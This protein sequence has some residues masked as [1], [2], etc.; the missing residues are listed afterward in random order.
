MENQLSPLNQAQLSALASLSSNLERD[1][2]L[3]LNGYFQGLFVKHNQQVAVLLM[4][5]AEK[6]LKI[7]YGTHTGRSERIAS[8]LADAVS[9]RGVDVQIVALDNYNVRQLASETNIVCIVSTHG[10]GEPPA[11]AEDFHAFIT[12]KRAPLLP[13]LKYAVVAL[14]DKSYRLFCKTGLDIDQAFSNAGAQAILPVL[15]LD[16]DYEEEASQWVSRFA[17]VFV[18]GRPGTEIVVKANPVTEKAVAYSAKNPFHATVLDKVKITGRDSDKEV[19]H[20]EL[21]LEGS[22]ITYEP[23]D[24]VGILANNPPELVESIL[25]ELNLSGT[26]KVLIRNTEYALREALTDRLEITVLNR[27]FVQNYQK[28][29]RSEKL[30]QI[31]QD[32]KL[33]ED[34]LFGRDVLDLVQ[35]FPHQPDAQTLA[36]LLRVIPARLYSISSSQ[37]VVG[38]EVHITVAAVRFTRKGRSRAGACSSYLAD[39]IQIN[40]TVPVYIEK[41]PSFK[42]PENKETPIILIGAGTGIAPY[43]AFLQQRE[44]EN[45]KGKTWLFFGERRFRSDFLYQVEWQKLL[46]DGVLEKLDVAFSRDHEEKIYVQH[47][48]AEKSREVFK[49][50]SGGAH[51]YLCGDMKNMA[52]DVQSGLLRI[53]EREGGMSAEKAGEFLKK[54]RKERRFQLDVY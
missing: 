18:A 38:N 31:V 28:L 6:K 14:G 54:L 20:L 35:E 25:H 50:L 23:G 11:M 34:F 1:Q 49:W 3:W 10:E 53:I 37:A 24:A 51:I 44:A 41:N 19:Y 12:G 2:L 26:E 21:S 5:P 40:S 39:R 8:Q 52:R 16:V 33:L 48:L 32:E 45:L 22:G 42:L 29:S 13:N 30:L 36:G 17:E 43:R 27:E 9:G 4:V 47:L 15:P 46:K 7:L